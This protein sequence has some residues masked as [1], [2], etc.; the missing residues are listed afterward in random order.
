MSR[1]YKGVFRP[2]NPR[3]YKGDASN[4]IYRSRWE[5]RFM[6]YCDNHPQIVEWASEEIFI[7]Y[8]SPKTRKFQRYFPDFLIKVM[9]KETRKIRTI[10]I[11]IKPFNQTQPPSEMSGKRKKPK[12]RLLTETM[13][14]AINTAKWNA[15]RAWCKKR[16]I[17]FKIMTEK[18][19][20]V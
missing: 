16:N 2:T 6:T 14:Y 9:D 17:E 4:I 13:T 1:T 8:L 15:A 20:N 3:K 19:L 12:N 18:D 11:E 10:M 7:P 5:L